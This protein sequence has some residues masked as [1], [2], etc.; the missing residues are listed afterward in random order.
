MAIPAPNNKSSNDTIL[1]YE[2]LQAED[3][4]GR[5]VSSFQPDKTPD[6][7]RP[8]SK[9]EAEFQNYP[10]ES[11]DMQDA[12]FNT[13]PKPA[14]MPDEQTLATMMGKLTQSQL[15][16]FLT[17]LGKSIESRLPRGKIRGKPAFIT[18]IIDEDGMLNVCSNLPNVDEV[19]KYIPS[20]KSSEKPKS[21]P[22]KTRKILL[23]E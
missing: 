4:F 6:S 19:Y 10:G 13:R 1:L 7:P 12:F 21:K 20:L 11:D 17:V 3:M 14:D 9:L 5:Q 2:R 23:D 22:A 8:N 15:N 16:R 18:L